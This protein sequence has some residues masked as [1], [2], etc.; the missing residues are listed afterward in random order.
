M[1]QSQEQVPTLSQ[2]E[3]N[4]SAMWEVDV[5]TAPRPQTHTIYFSEVILGQHDIVSSQ[6]DENSKLLSNAMDWV[7]F[8]WMESEYF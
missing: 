7:I 4:I 8:E 6:S 5:T 1:R 2:W 3:E